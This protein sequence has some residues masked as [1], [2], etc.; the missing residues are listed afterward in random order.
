MNEKQENI[1]LDIV[2][3]IR[4]NIT[5][6]CNATSKQTVVCAECPAYNKT[7]KRCFLE[8]KASEI[9]ELVKYLYSEN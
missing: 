7:T 2:D 4:E 8:E 3:S 9:E 1:I 5:Y 6:F